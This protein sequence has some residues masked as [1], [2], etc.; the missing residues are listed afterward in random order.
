MCFRS[1]SAWRNFRDASAPARSATLALSG[2][3]TPRFKGEPGG[4]RRATEGLSGGL[5]AATSSGATSTQMESA[6]LSVA[7]SWIHHAFEGFSGSEV[8]DV[9]LD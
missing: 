9:P 2:R 7:R 3:V 8:C 1:R 4:D 5:H 6:R